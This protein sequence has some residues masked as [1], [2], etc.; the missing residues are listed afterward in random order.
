MPSFQV[1]NRLLTKYNGTRAFEELAQ[2]S[3]HVFKVSFYQVRQGRTWSRSY[4]SPSPTRFRIL[5][6][7]HPIFN[8]AIFLQLF[9]NFLPTFCR[10]FWQLFWQLL[11]TFWQSFDNFWKLF[12]LFFWSSVQIVQLV[13]F[14]YF[15]IFSWHFIFR[16]LSSLI[17]AT[18]LRTI[19]FL[20]FKKW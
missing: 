16:Y 12:S 8:F 14:I 4:K 17:V 1:N 7:L 19:Q 6:Y 10:L 3:C 2:V 20:F 15:Y 9:E 13:L 11:T 5:V 18:G